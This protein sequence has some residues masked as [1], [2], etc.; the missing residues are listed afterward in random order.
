MRVSYGELKGL[1]KQSLIERSERSSTVTL[2]N[3]S[4]TDGGSD[5]HVEDMQA[6]LMGL[7]AL[8][9]QHRYGTAARAKFADASNHL[10]K[11]IHRS[12]KQPSQQPPRTFSQLEDD[13]GDMDRGDSIMGQRSSS[14]R[15]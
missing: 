5:E 14:G 11:L 3:G 10:K 4:I 15:E 8:K 13:H 1:I 6:I 7:E 9:K 2:S 12:K